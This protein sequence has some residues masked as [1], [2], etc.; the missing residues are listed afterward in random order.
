[1]KDEHWVPCCPE[2]VYLVPVLC[3]HSGSGPDRLCQGVAEVAG[4]HR[5]IA[6]GELGQRVFD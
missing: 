1:M 2:K 6:A 5:Q 3:D 4:E